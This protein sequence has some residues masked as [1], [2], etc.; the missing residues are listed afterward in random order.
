MLRRFA[1]AV[2]LS[3]VLAAAQ[4]VASIPAEGAPVFDYRQ[5]IALFEQGERR[6]A[7]CLLYRGQYRAR[8][9]LRAHPD[10]EPSA[11]PALYASLNETV[12]RPINEWAAGDVPEWVQSMRC[13]LDWAREHDDPYTPKAAYG[14]AH[15][16][17]QAGFAR[18]IDSTAARAEEIRRIRAQNGLENR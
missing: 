15:A 3:P 14:D 16:E 11:D 7:T 4:E 13:A 5:A 8:V 2:L 9:H 6:Q 12:G 17:V 1:L 18:F 10:L